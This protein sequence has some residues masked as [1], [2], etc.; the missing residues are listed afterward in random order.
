MP[1]FATMVMLKNPEGWRSFPIPEAVAD[2]MQKEL[3]CVT[4]GGHNRGLRWET[5]DG[6]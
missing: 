1:D 2:R 5:V 4:A 6:V 3:G